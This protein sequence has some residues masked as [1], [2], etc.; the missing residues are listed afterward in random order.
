MFTEATDSSPRAVL[1]VP[2]VTI[3]VALAVSNI[4]LKVPGGIPRPGVAPLGGAHG[5]ECGASNMPLLASAVVAASILISILTLY[6]LLTSTALSGSFKRALPLI[7]IVACGPS[8]EEQVTKPG[9]KP[10]CSTLIL[11][12]HNLA[13]TP[14]TREVIVIEE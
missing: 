12:T 5:T 7:I 14:P 1:R 2:D 6:Q 3:N 4:L 11:R 8:T 13:A 9:S 10:C